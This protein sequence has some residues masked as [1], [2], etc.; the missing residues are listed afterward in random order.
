MNTEAIFETVSFIM[1]YWFILLAGLILVLMFYISVREYAGKK[2]ALE[3]LGQFLG[4]LEITD[5]PSELIGIRIGVTDDNTIGSSR[6]AEIMIKAEGVAK[7]HAR[8]FLDSA[9]LYIAPLEQGQT[10]VNG[11]KIRKIYEVRDGDYI[12]IGDVELYLCLKGMNDAEL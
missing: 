12:E 6:S 3:E 7:K 8:L 5:G 9:R 4:Y 1:R 10:T 2:L 11:K